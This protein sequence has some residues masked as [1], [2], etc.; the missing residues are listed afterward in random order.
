M[1]KDYS[2]FSPGQPVKR[3]LF[4]GRQDEI[5]LLLGKVRNST[6][7]RI[8]V[9]FLTGERGIGK[10][11]LASFVKYVAEKNE[12]VLGL[13]TFL[14]GVSDL[15]DMVNS[16]FDHMLNEIVDKPW[17]DNLKEFFKKRISEVDIFG[18]T[19]KFKADDEELKHFVNHFD[20]ALKNLYGRIKDSKTGLFIILD[21]ING[22]SKLPEFANW[23]KS[24]V[25]AVSTARTT[26]PICLLLVGIEERRLEIT[27]NHPSLARVFDLVEIKAWHHQE[28][29]DFYMNA[30]SKVGVSVGMEASEVLVGCAGGL[31]VLAHEIGDAV[32]YSDNDDYIDMGDAYDGVMIAAET[33]GRKHL[34]LQVFRSIKSSRYRSILRKL[35]NKG[36]N[37][38]ERAKDIELLNRNE[39]KIFDKFLKRMLDL[40]VLVRDPMGKPGAYRFRNLLHLLYY[41]MEEHLR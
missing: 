5:H 12:N 21:E 32:F 29:R 31:P 22:L 9:V 17:Y 26:L 35:A 11:S 28:T 27:A 23:L 14:G 39:G 18:T 36:T 4:I 25:D 41:R 7:G 16:I 38:I 19:F 10:S 33:V 40:G 1:P 37:R 15:K 34:E 2:P 30:F 13:H 6:S 20:T 24:F 8:N 3:D